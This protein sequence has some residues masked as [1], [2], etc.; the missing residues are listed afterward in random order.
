MIL[1]VGVM[2]L[3]AA[4]IGAVFAVLYREGAAEQFK[5]GAK[6]FAALAGGGLAVGLIQFALFR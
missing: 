6:V 2:A 3:C 5:F 1:H 4:C